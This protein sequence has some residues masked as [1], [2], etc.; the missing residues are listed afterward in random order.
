MSRA[1]LSLLF[2]LLTVAARLPV[3]LAH[4]DA[5]QSFEVHT[6]NLAQGF[7]DGLDM[8]IERM[9]AMPHNRG[10][11]P[12]AL[13]LAPF[14]AVLGPTAFAM[15]LFPVLW[16]AFTVLLLVALFDRFFN[17][18]AAWA[19]GWLLVLAPPMF[20][21]LS[22]L[23]YA[24]HMEAT[25]FMA[26]PLWPF[27]AITLEGKADMR[28]Y[29]GFGLATGAAGFFH[30]Q[31]LLFCLGL[32]VLLIIQR[33]RATLTKGLLA[34]ALGMAITGGPSFLFPGGNVDYVSKA[35]FKDKPPA[36]APDADR[37][38]KLQ[39]FFEG[40][41]VEALDFGEAGERAGVILGSLWLAAL[42]AA[43]ATA[44]WDE[45]ARLAQLFRR[46]FTFRAGEVSPL[47]VFVFHPFAVLALF[48]MTSMS[49]N[50]G[51]L[52]S[53][54]E[55]RRLVPVV[56]S[57]LLLAAAGLGGTGRRPAPSR[58]RRG[59]LVLLILVG[60]AGLVATGRPNPA[61][62]I[63]QRG[64]AYEWFSVHL[65]HH[66]GGDPDALVDTILEL[67]RG[68]LRFAT[69]RYTVGYPGLAVNRPGDLAREGRLLLNGDTP[70]VL[71]RAT[72]VGRALGARRTAAASP[73]LTAMLDTLTPTL[74][75]AV[76]HGLGLGLPKMRPGGQPVA[77]RRAQRQLLDELQGWSPADRSA[78]LEGYAFPRGFSLMPYIPALLQPLTDFAALPEPV[79][80]AFMRGF[81][82]GYR[83][84]WLQVPD[85]VPD[86]LAIL[87]AVPDLGRRALIE[88]L[89]GSNLPPEAEAMAAYVAR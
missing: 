66:T 33:P 87:Q 36:T 16:H 17:R 38:E 4:D 64:E 80:D 20:T 76:L 14:Y 54:N 12:S 67:D 85:A 52:G 68:D 32:F 30:L 48:F 82:W 1:K 6:G 39:N 2:L 69:L 9:P 49:L 51:N 18:R 81:G 57:L 61:A 31:A 41:A 43:C 7:L 79:R 58:G 44:V 46:V 55:N 24:S 78:I 62:A 84:R 60:A 3:L 75:A 86:E 73:S 77:Y 13:L 15:K 88:G 56:F 63:P 65:A 27:F 40:G 23:G 74:R 45:R 22:V 11:A 10:N 71:F 59:V 8:K 37:V 70:H 72:A 35:L 53:G 89:I 26:L 19:C 25:L 34:G 29:L 42:L 21:K 47:A 5:W 83:Q 28:R 50:L